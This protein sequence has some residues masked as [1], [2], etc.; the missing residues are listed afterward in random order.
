MSLEKNFP[1]QYS[2][3]GKRFAGLVLIAVGII[4]IM[5][6]SGFYVPE[7]ILA[8]PMIVIAVGLYIG[9]KHNFKNPAWWIVTL[10]GGLF[11]ADYMIPE[12][13]FGKFMWPVAIIALGLLMLFG[14]GKRKRHRDHWKHEYYRRQF[15]KPLETD[16]TEKTGNFSSEDYIDSVSIFGGIQKNILSKNF[17]GGSVVNIFSGAEINLSQAEFTGQITLE[18]ENIM[19]GTSIIVPADWEIHTEVVNI[20]G[21]VEDR[22]PQ[23]NQTGSSNKKMIL[24]GTTVFGGIEI[25]SY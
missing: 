19:G 2:P 18:L 14:K 22:R 3:N 23:N 15:E 20:I 11:M 9:F 16:A 5:K 8:W 21:A 25:K 10:V 4:F 17:K 6:K 1:E 13:T 12:I 24:K 7:W